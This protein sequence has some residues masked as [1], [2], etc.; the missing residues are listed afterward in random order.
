MARVPYVDPAS[1]PDQYP[2]LE[3]VGDQFPGGVSVERWNSAPTTRA[4][5]N[6]PALAAMHVHA[7]VTLWAK[8]G[9]S[10]RDVELV[11]LAVARALDSPF[12]WHPH[13]ITAIEYAGVTRAEV[14]AISH[15]DH[16]A[17][18]DRDR[19]LVEYASAFVAN[20]GLVPD[21]THDALAAAFTDSQVVGVA[22]L[23][24]F[25]VYL[26]YVGRALELDRS[27]PFVGWDLENYHPE[28]SRVTDSE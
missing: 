10:I 15:R 8:C 21:D 9:L 24:G 28:E 11:I 13:V 7:N 27:E 20:D 19:V 5:G 1:L 18:A 6:N 23:T 17:L 12:E 3:E 22:M 26:E 2:I 25:Y 4:F 16:D 14:L